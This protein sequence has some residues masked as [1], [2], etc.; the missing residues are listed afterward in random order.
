LTP[1]WVKRQGISLA[2]FLLFLLLAR[3]P[4]G[5]ADP[6]DGGTAPAPLP[7]ISRLDRGDTLFLQYQED[8]EYARRRLF[9]RAGAGREE[10]GREL[11]DALTVYRYVPKE[12]EDL[13]SLAAR[14]NIPYAALAT[15][16]RLSHPSLPSPGTELLLPSAP[17]LFVPGEPDSDLEQL[18]AAARSSRGGG[19]DIR[20][21]LPP[22]GQAGAA[23]FRFFP[24]EDFSPTERIFFLHRGFRFPLRRF[25]LTSAFGPR[26]N[27]VTGRVRVHQGLDLA[28]P[29]GTAVFAAGDGVVTE[30]GSDP[31]YGNYIVIRHRDDWASL[32]GHLSRIAVGLRQEVRS[33][34]LIGNVGSTGQSTGPHLHF[35]L[36]RNGRAQDPGK[37]LF[38]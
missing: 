36:R 24:G 30:T 28:A 31:V 3:P 7:L 14:C 2:F 6:P 22:A 12:G 8:V 11:A 9:G 33:G 32:Y 27:P 21:G 20:I 37:Y 17:G 35:E 15:L 26:V 13:L 25:T 34:T 18:M 4:A 29:A 19:V 16:N 5:A 1:D 23:A 10:Q 38:E